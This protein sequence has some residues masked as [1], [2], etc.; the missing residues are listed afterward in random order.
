MYAV[1]HH[2][3]NAKCSRGNSAKE[4]FRGSRPDI[5]L[6]LFEYGITGTLARLDRNGGTNDTGIVTDTSYVTCG[7]QDPT[8][9]RNW[10]L[11]K[12]RSHISI[13]EHLQISA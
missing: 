13:V 1:P 9:P 3:L 7:P 8:H 10:P 4:S 6:F 5:L 12:K 11:R 2:Q